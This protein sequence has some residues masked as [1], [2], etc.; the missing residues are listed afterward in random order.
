MAVARI[1]AGAVRCLRTSR[2]K[3]P[4]RSAPRFPAAGITSSATFQSDAR[5]GQCCLRL[6]R[7]ASTRD[8]AATD[9]QGALLAGRAAARGRLRGASG[10]SRGAAATLCRTRCADTSAAARAV[11]WPEDTA[12]AA[13]AGP[14]A[15]ELTAA[16]SA[17]LRAESSLACLC[18]SL[19][20]SLL[21]GAEVASASAV[22]WQEPCLALL[23]TSR[24]GK[25]ACVAA[26]AQGCSAQQQRAARGRTECRCRRCGRR[27]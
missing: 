6:P 26:A 8:A 10:D 7:A 27:P 15:S 13:P 20:V 1:I 4:P 11:R 19:S 21:Q 17:L 14:S 12:A 16:S 18:C 3:L 9:A 24:V 5:T 2:I 23:R 22:R 25:H